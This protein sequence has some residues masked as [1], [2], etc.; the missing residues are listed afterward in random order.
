VFPRIQSLHSL[1]RVQP[2]LCEQG[3][4]IDRRI[5]ADVVEGCDSRGD[6]PSFGIFG[7]FVRAEIAQDDVVYIWMQLK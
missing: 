1:R 4:G 5:G 3:N 2:I 6:A 7:E